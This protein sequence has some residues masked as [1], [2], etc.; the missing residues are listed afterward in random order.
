[1]RRAVASILRV[2]WKVVKSVHAAGF[3]NERI[4]NDEGRAVCEN[5]E[6]VATVAFWVQSA[7][8]LSLAVREEYFLQNTT[9]RLESVLGCFVASCSPNERPFEIPK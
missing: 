7:E 4:E 3:D 1:M 6:R 8:S 2:A 9:R 5:S